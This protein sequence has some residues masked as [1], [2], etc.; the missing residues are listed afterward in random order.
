MGGIWK[1]RLGET[2]EK[3][4]EN[5]A[6][7]LMVLGAHADLQAAMYKCLFGDDESKAKGQEALPN[8]VKPLLEGLERALERKT[9]E[10]PF[11]ICESGPTLADLAVYDLIES[12]FP[13]LKKLGFDMAPYTKLV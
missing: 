4:S 5:R 2:I 9:C 7:E 12:P 10:G 8:T 3:C 13:G 11:F 6:T 1:D